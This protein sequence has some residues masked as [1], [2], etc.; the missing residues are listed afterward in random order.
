MVMVWVGTG[1]VPVQDIRPT[2]KVNAGMHNNEL[3]LQTFAKS[4][5]SC[6]LRHSGSVA[7]WAARFFHMIFL[8]STLSC[9]LP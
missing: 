1:M 9:I 5:L 8:R 2:E 7:L 4:D 3:P 6:F